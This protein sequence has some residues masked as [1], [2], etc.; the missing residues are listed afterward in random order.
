MTYLPS[1]KNQLQCNYLC[2]DMRQ[3]R[4]TQDDYILIPKR[5]GCF[6]SLSQ[7][8]MQGL[9]CIGQQIVTHEDIR[10]CIITS[11]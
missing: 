6:T 11:G 8:L 1:K 9:F 2:R 10:I 5:I 3:G 4:F 7:D